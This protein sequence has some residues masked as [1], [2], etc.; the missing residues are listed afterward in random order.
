M[1]KKDYINPEK[2]PITTH[3]D[4][5]KNPTRAYEEQNLIDCVSWGILV[6]GAQLGEIVTPEIRK[7]IKELEIKLESNFDEEVK[8]V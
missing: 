8:N 4:L 3:P 1:Y 6:E 7:Q 5:P 2:F